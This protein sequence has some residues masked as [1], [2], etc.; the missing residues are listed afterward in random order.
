MDHYQLERDIEHL[1]RVISHISADDRIPLAYWRNRVNSVS[2]DVLGPS[3]ASRV[4]RLNDALSA[5][6]ARAGSVGRR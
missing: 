2:G 5:L 1:E 4:K 3:Q 6:E